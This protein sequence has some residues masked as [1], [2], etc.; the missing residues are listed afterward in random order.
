MVAD[1]GAQRGKGTQLKADASGLGGS[2]SQRTLLEGNIGATAAEEGV[3]R[4]K[5]EKRWEPLPWFRVFHRV[6]TPEHIH[7]FSRR[8]SAKHMQIANADEFLV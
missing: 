5:V 1:Q 2:G 4:I 3:Q 8:A 6:T 7:C